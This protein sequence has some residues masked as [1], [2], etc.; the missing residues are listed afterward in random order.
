[1]PPTPPL[2]PDRRIRLREE[3]L[4]ELALTHLDSR[5]DHDVKQD[6]P[7]APY[8]GVTDWT[9]PVDG[10]I[11][12][13]AWDWFATH[14]GDVRALRGVAPRSNL[15]VIDAKGYDMPPPQEHQALWRLIDTMSWQQH[16]RAALGM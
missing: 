16:V 4:A 1:M 15:Q 3:Q 8:A 14:D 7:D 10:F 5:E 9:A 6:A 2:A 12:S 13:I 11:V